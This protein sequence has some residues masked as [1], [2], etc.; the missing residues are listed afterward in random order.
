MQPDTGITS[1]T[2]DLVSLVAQQVTD[3]LTA[4]PATELDLR[5]RTSLSY[6]ILVAT[7]NVRWSVYAGNA[8]DF[9]DE[10]VIQA[11]ATVLVGAVG[12]FSTALAVFAYYHVKL[13]S[14]VAGV[15]GTATVTGLAKK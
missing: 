10:S 8:P 11:E 7:Q 1:N 13:R 6:T 4:Y 12:T 3:P 5:K 9:S 14:A 2:F 15:P